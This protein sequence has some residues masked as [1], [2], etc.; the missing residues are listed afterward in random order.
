MAEGFGRAEAL[1]ALRRQA[2]MTQEEL[3]EAAEVAVRTVRR[4]ET[5]AATDFRMGTVR[6]VANV[7]ADAV[8]R[9]RDEVW[10]ELDGSSKQSVVRSAAGP[11]P[12]HVGPIRPRP[13]L[14]GL[15]AVAAALARSVQDRWTREEEQRRIHHPRP[16]LVRWHAA[17]S[18]FAEQVSH[19]R[20]VG[21]LSG[22]A[23]TYRSLDTGRLVVLGRAGS[24]KTVL[25]LRF[26]LDYLATRVD[27]EPVPVVFSLGAWDPTAV[28][29][30]DWLVH[31][32][33]RD[34]PELGVSAPG[35][36]SM[37]AALLADGWILPV[38]DGFDEI[39][40]RWQDRA[41]EEL[42]ATRLPMLLTGRTSPLTERV[43][44][45][46]VFS[47][48]AGIELDDLTFDD[49]AGYLPGTA[50]PGTT[51]TA[52]NLVL[53]ELIQQ[54]EKPQAERLLKVLRTPL[55]TLVAR[56][57]YSDVPDNDPG[58]LLDAERFPTVT[59][60]EQ[61]L[62]AGFV[63]ALYRRPYT[64]PATGA[65][66]RVPRRQSPSWTAQQAGQYATHL[67]VHARHFKDAAGQD[68]AWWRLCDS[69]RPASRIL[70]VVLAGIALTVVADMLAPLLFIALRNPTSTPVPQ[71]FVTDVFIFGPLVGLSFGFI[72][73]LTVL[74]GRFPI[75]PSRIRIR[76][77]FQRRN[78]TGLSGHGRVGTW[79]AYGFLGGTVLGCG[80]GLARAVQ[81]LAFVRSPSNT[82]FHAAFSITLTDTAVFSLIFGLAA[83]LS[84][85]LVATLSVP[86]T[87][88]APTPLSL[89]ADARITAVRQLLVLIPALALAIAGGGKLVVEAGQVLFG[90]LSWSFA[91]AA[92]MG[93]VG[94]VLGATMYTLAFTAWGQWLLLTRLWLP[95]TGRLP[96][97]TAAFLDD[98]YHRGLLRQVGTV[99]QFRHARLQAQL[100]AA[101]VSGPNARPPVQ[102]LNATSL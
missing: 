15:E 21:D 62:L 96:W 71:A 23:E 75:E 27:D 98:A 93:A 33:L 38:L 48:A 25:A 89:L 81:N 41:L 94:G 16:L 14:G 53:E 5:G 69:V 79:F 28:G 85:G 84:L 90:P 36:G 66:G 7:L 101:P 8:R 57:I 4:L 44:A 76:L 87:E 54:P 13:G 9:D 24:G 92:T 73:A 77:L 51:A 39:A 65:D 6:M 26:V 1:R 47:R 29:L 52:W 31:R 19:D 61:H 91:T 20:S 74:P 17:R 42:N 37:A 3:A 12:S 67:A 50:P 68:I 82:S 35:R 56:T 11:V 78:A 32:L 70:A 46:R 10:R 2:G 40:E 43:S 95:L 80:Y 100:L 86:D 49:L 72:Y 63:P 99:Y 18:G 64:Y 58:E 102:D 45:T 83:S 55:M 22:I 88:S 30:R 97:A 60:L 34:H 59:A